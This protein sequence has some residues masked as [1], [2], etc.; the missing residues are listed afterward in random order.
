MNISGI[1]L[2][3]L[4]FFY[5]IYSYQ[6]TDSITG[7]VTIGCILLGL[8]AGLRHIA[9]GPDTPTYY[10]YF[11]Q[12]CQTSWS[13]VLQ[14][15]TS[16]ISEFRDPAFAV[17]EKLFSILVPSW[18]LF[19]IIIAAFYFYGLWRVLMRYV[20]SL[21]GAL[22]S[23]VLYLSL[24][25]IVALSGLR[26]CITTGIAF[27]LIPMINDREWKIVVPIIILGSTIHI[28][29][30]FMLAFIPL[31]V[32]PNKLQKFIYFISILLIPVIAAGARG[33][34]SYMT[35][36]LA[37]DY[38]SNYVNSDANSENPIMYVAVLSIIA[39]YEYLNYNQ[40][41]SKGNTSF[42]V[43]SNILMVVTVPLIFVDGTM[44]RIGQYFTLYVIV[45][46]PLIFERSSYRQLAYFICIALLAVR[47]FM[48]KDVY[49]FFW[50]TVPGFTY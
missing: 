12:V 50:E 39:I 46:L 37:N 4:L 11:Q 14:G 41:T 21:E 5:L 10:D 30:L 35:S 3:I 40:L 27:L 24:F 19:L 47:I 43:P 16:D 44:I 26:Q 42:L 32:L 8:E 23:F 15:F 38:Y 9:V 25:N 28:S 18:Q 33:I 34:I 2:V 7:F 17:I 29:L 13:E 1:I 31:I 48:T 49:Y 36:F 22:L 20:E 6:K 45:S